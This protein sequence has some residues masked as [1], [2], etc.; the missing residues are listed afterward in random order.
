M[1]ATTA[2]FALLGIDDEIVACDCCGK[3]N[4]KCTVALSQLDADGNEVAGVRF[5]RDCAARAL[6]RR[7]TTADKMELGAR[8]VSAAALAAGF[9][10]WNQRTIGEGWGKMTAWVSGTHAA[11]TTQFHQSDIRCNLDAFVGGTWRYIGACPRAGVRVF[12]RA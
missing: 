5:G 10:G 6:G 11:V 8:T 9:R 1:N 12:A 2:R 3:K 7:R 4:L